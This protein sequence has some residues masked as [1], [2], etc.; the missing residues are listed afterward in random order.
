[1]SIKILQ[2]SC[3]DV[4]K[5]LEANSV[6]CVVTS[7]PYWGLR[8]YGI[9]GQLG[10]ETTPEAYARN[11]VRIFREIKRV[12]H[13]KGT[14][15]LNLGDCFVGPNHVEFSDR[16]VPIRG[17]KGV[18]VMPKGKWQGLP[19]KNLIGIPWRVAFAL[20][21]DGWYLRTEIVWHKPNPIP[22]TVKD[23]PT[24]A[25]EYIFLLTRSKK[26]F[27]DADAI[28]EPYET[29]GNQSWK[30]PK[31]KNKRN[32]WSVPVQPF[33]EGHFATYPP[34]LIEPCILAGC[35]KG[36]TVLDPF[37][38][39]GTTA[40]VTERTGRNCIGIELNA[41]YIKIAKKRLGLD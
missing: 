24:R 26:Y 32:V 38:G 31:G 6:H 14:V 22:E 2:G 5:T 35:P 19:V 7:P 41:E 13:P 16:S 33:R 20:Q 18:K 1:M 37:F 15:W 21:K 25:L 8:D 39:A 9:P 30:H 11:L 34:D 27:Y 3:K 4:L 23:R 12:L 36:G 10:M 28:R 17:R 40:L 29:Q